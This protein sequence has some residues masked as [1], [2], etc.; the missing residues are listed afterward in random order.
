MTPLR[1]RKRG[2]DVRRADDVS[3]RRGDDEE[4]YR[5][6]HREHR[7]HYDTRRNAAGASSGEDIVTAR[8]AP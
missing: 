2:R 7:V 4:P 8:L 5:Q 3:E 6:Q 1:M